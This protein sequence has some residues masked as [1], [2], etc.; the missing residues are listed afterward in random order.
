MVRVTRPGG[1][2]GDPGILPAA[3]LVLRPAVS[4]LLPPPA[5]AGRPDVSHD[6]GQCLPL[7]ARERHGVPRRRGAGRAAARPRIDRG[8]LAS[9][10][11]RHRHAV[12]R[13]EARQNERY[14]YR[15]SPARPRRP[16]RSRRAAAGLGHASGRPLGPG[17]QPRS[18]RAVRSTSSPKTSS[19]PPG[20]R[21]CRAASASMRLSSSTTSPRCP[22]R[23]ACRSP[24]S[25]R[26]VRCP[27]G[28]SAPWP[29]SNGWRRDPPPERFDH[30]RQLLASGEG[31]A[32]RRAAGDRLRRGAVHRGDLLH[33]HRQG[34]G[35][36]APLRRRAAA[37]LAGTA[38]SAERG[39]GRLPGH[40]GRATGPTRISSSIPGPAC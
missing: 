11:V 9:V 22:W 32:A 3:G 30:I 20:R 29:M 40:A 24:C 38:R 17:V 37:R 10:H 25:R 16:R 2:G 12:R 35:R 23:W 31:R 1:Q 19:W 5:A 34:H 28:R 8:A 13:R 39:D 26:R 18:G 6:H 14:D 15:L 4:L 36:H 21:C 27:I 7:S 33:R